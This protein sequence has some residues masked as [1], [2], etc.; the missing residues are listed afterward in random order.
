MSGPTLKDIDLARHLLRVDFRCTRDLQDA[1][2]LLKEQLPEPAFRAY[3]EPIAAAIA[4]VGNALSNRVIA[5]HPELEQEID[6]SLATY[7][8]IL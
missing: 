7:G 8:R 6:A 5:E 3:A 4:A 2:Q 1:L